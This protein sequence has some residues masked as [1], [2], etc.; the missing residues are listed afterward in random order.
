MNKDQIKQIHWQILKYTYQGRLYDAMSLIK[1]QGVVNVKDDSSPLAIV[2][3]TYKMMLRYTV[4][5]MNDPN[6]AAIFRQMQ[7]SLLLIADS[8]R[9]ALMKKHLPSQIFSLAPLVMPTKSPCHDNIGKWFDYILRSENVARD[10]SDTLVSF[11]GDNE[12][13]YSDQSLI[14]S[15]L[16]LSCLIFFDMAKYRLLVNIYLQN[17]EQIWQRALVGIAILSYYFNKRIRLFP[18]AKKII[19]MLTGSDKFQARYEATVI[20][21]I[22][23][24]GTDKITKKINEEIIPQVTKIAPGIKDRMKADA[25]VSEILDDKNPAWKDYILENKDLVD[26]MTEMTKLQLEGSDVFINSFAQLKHYA[27]FNNI[28]NWF[29]PFSANNPVVREMAESASGKE[30]DLMKFARNIAKTPYICNSDKYSFCLSVGLMPPDQRK[31]L[32]KYV[33]MEFNEMNEI[34]KEEQLLHR[35][36]YSYKTLIQYIQDIYRFFKL[37]T[38]GKDFIDVFSKGFSPSGTMLFDM[39]FADGNKKRNVGEFFFANEY[40]GSAYDIFEQLSLVAPN[41]EIYQKMGYAAQ[42]NGDIR[43]AL[44]NYLKAQLFEDK[45][46]WNLKKVGWCYR[47]LG[48]PAKALEYYKLAEAQDIN[49]LSVATAIGRCHLELENYADALKYYYKVEYLDTKNTKVLA[50]I[51]WCNYSTGKYEQSL[52]Y[53]AK[54]L[55]VDA[56]PEIHVLSGHNCRKLGNLKDAVEHYKNAIGC[57]DYKMQDLAEAIAADYKDDEGKDLTEDNNLILDYINYSME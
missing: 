9:N 16:T 10:T 15:A 5:G 29:L 38:L 42:K 26:K 56:S 52:K 28:E 20:Q 23:A 39:A 8:V 40:Y 47:K 22:R 34:S 35:E 21:M 50:P 48:E 24:I 1:A 41:F 54:L 55:A 43:L 32:G 3:Q 11:C 53:C 46:L 25:T 19:A 57:K 44:D 36:E 4:E 37:N 13:N 45:Q 33:G 49:D 31:T 14:V 51:A 2:E 7:V 27:F 18:E 12:G 6:R 30:F 17:R